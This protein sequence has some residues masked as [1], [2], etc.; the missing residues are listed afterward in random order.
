M[1]SKIKWHNHDDLDGLHARMGASQHSWVNYDD[2]KWADIIKNER[3]KEKGTEL[4]MIAS[5]LSKYPNDIILAPTTNTINMFVNDMR[6]YDMRS[7]QLLYFSN[8]CFGTADAI[9]FDDNF[10][11]IHDL[12]TGV[13][14]VSMVQLIIYAA[15]FCLEYGQDPEKMDVE[16][17][18][19]QNNDVAIYIPDSSEIREIMVKIVHDDKL[20]TRLLKEAR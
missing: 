18:I 20:V 12:K 13:G 10:L 9:S 17:R 15:L 4:H 6:D 8:N 1:S 5:L 14:K 7:E 2:E 11:R 16:L 19:Y 3:A